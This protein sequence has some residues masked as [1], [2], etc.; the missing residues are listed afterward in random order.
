MSNS[1][2]QDTDNRRYCRYHIRCHNKTPEHT[3][4]YICVFQKECRYANKCNKISDPEHTKYFCHTQSQEHSQDRIEHEREIPLEQRQWSSIVKAAKVICAPPPRD[5]TAECT[6]TLKSTFVDST[7]VTVSG[8]Y[9]LLCIVNT[10]IHKLEEIFKSIIIQRHIGDRNVVT[11]ELNVDVEVET[12][13]FSS[14]FS[15]DT[16]PVPTH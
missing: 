7:C 11:Q 16:I 12:E 2:A 15:T 1:T 9:K 4:N 3:N 5:C 14:S 8:N 13:D 10:P 6:F